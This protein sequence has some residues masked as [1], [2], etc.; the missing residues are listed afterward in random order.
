[1]SNEAV[2]RKAVPFEGYKTEI[3][4]LTEFWW[5]FEKIPLFQRGK[6]LKCHNSGCIKDIFFGSMAWFSEL[7]NSAIDPSQLPVRVHGT[8]C[9]S[10]YV[11]LGYRWL[12]SMP[13][14]RHTYFPQCLKP[15]RICVIYDFFAPHINVLTYLLT[16]LQTN[17]PN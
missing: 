12:L 11:T 17:R 6:S 13:N 10:V 9:R 14:W 15:R 8:S 3:S 7:A 4:Y 1:M 16:Y 5:K 2:L